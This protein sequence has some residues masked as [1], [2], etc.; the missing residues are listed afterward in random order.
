MH[1]QANPALQRCSLLLIEDN[2]LIRD[3]VSRDLKKI[4]STEIVEVSTAETG[5]SY[6]VGEKARGFH[7]VICDLTLPGASG[8]SLIKKLRMLPGRAKTIPI[9]VLTADSSVETFKSL[10]GCNVASYLI[11]PV[12]TN[13]LKS[14]IEV[15][16]GLAV[17]PAKFSS[18]ALAEVPAAAPAAAKASVAPSPLVPHLDGHI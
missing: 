14:S 7:I 13:L 2:R 4:G 8:V 16:L 15:A 17:A 10:V 1:P 5:W 6:L 3:L 9:I 12:S 18:E 11:K